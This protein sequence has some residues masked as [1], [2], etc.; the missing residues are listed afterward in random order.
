MLSIPHDLI[1]LVVIANIQTEIIAAN[2]QRHQ[3]KIAKP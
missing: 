1:L 3:L 2:E